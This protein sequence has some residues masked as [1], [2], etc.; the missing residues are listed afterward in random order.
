MLKFDI[1]YEEG[2]GN[3]EDNPDPQPEISLTNKW[4]KENCKG[5]SN[6]TA[7]LAERSKKSNSKIINNIY[8]HNRN[9]TIY[10]K[11]SKIS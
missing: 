3:Q 11:T 1:D 5:V 10:P 8:S 7:F 2:S 9:I 4:Y 6:P